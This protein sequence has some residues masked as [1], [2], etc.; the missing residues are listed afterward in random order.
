MYTHG[1][2]ILKLNIDGVKITSNVADIMT[3]HFW[4]LEG[5]NTEVISFRQVNYELSKT[6]ESVSKYSELNWLKVLLTVHKI[7]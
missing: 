3:Y 6:C 4:G 1:A 7:R 5:G 2:S